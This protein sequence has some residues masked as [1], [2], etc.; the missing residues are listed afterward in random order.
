MIHL[1]R[2]KRINKQ[3]KSLL[4]EKKELSLYCSNNIISF[5]TGNINPSLPMKSSVWCL[6]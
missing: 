6:N 2:L 3:Y 4:P 5:S 1:S